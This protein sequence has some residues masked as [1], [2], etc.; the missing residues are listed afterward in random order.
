MYLHV[1]V[2]LR[3]YNIYP[4]VFWSHTVQLIFCGDFLQL[5]P[6]P[7]RHCVLSRDQPPKPTVVASALPV[8][9][10]EFNALT[11]QT[12]CFKTGGFEVGSLL[13]YYTASH[14]D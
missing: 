10:L 7:S 4:R 5:S 1:M 14:M 8:A 11:F 13:Y 6:V 9:V 3:A 2:S 12:A